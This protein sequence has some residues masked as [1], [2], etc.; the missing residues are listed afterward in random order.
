MWGVGGGCEI[1]AHIKRLIRQAAAHSLDFR[2]REP[3]PVL[4]Q[5]R[6]G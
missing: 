3:F 4:K 5:L 2:Y 1:V 6:E